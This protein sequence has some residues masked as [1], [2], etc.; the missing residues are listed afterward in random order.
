MAFRW[1]NRILGNFFIP[2]RAMLQNSGGGKKFIDG[3]LELN[4]DMGVYKMTDFN[5]LKKIKL[6]KHDGDHLP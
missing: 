1:R 5:H 4:F 6:E 2:A 3:A